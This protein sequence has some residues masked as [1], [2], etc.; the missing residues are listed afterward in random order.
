MLFNDSALSRG[1][2]GAILRARSF[3]VATVWV[4]GCWSSPDSATPP[5]P[6]HVLL[7]TV[8]TLRSD[9]LSANGYDLPTTPYLDALLAGGVHFPRALAP[10]PRTTPALASLL[11]GAYPH[12][13][14]VRTLYGA[15]DDGVLSLAELFQRRGYHTVAVVSNHVLTPERRLDR[16]FEVYD[17]AGDAR[18]ATATT[19][20]VLRCVDASWR[21]RPVFLWVHYI[22][23]HVP[24]WPPQ[25][26]AARFDP[27]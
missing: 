7:L 3:F 19:D 21:E 5:A 4:A 6:Q 8:D 26:L 14:G 15:L 13:T 18:D 1:G 27:G 10:V 25:E 23:P 22:D 11:T 24:Y 2:S 9:H 17:A 16:G 20:A 12:T